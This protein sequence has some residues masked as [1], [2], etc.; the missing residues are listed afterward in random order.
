VSLQVKYTVTSHQGLVRGSNEDII[1]A[2]VTTKMDTAGA[3]LRIQ[4]LLICDGMGGMKAGET[5][6][7]LASIS[8]IDYIKSMPFWPSLES[9]IHQQLSD[10]INAAHQNIT[11]LS[12]Y[13]FATNGMGTTIVL[14][15][16]VKDHA[17]L[18]WCGDSRA[19]LHTTRIIAQGIN[20]GG[21]QLL[22]RDHSV[23]WEMVANGVLTVDQA[24]NHPKSN[25]LTQSLGGLHPPNPD[26]VSLPI[27][28]GDRFLLCSDGV[29][30]HLDSSEIKSCLNIHS[31]LELAAQA[32]SSFILERGAKDNFSIGILDVV[33]VQFAEPVL[34]VAPLASH[35]NLSR[36]SNLWHKWWITLPV[37]LAL[38]GIVYG[39]LSM[40]FIQEKQPENSLPTV[41]PVIVSN[42]NLER[43]HRKLSDATHKLEQESAKLQNITDH[44]VINI[45]K[46]TSAVFENNL[47]QNKIPAASVAPQ[48]PVKKV[49]KPSIKQ[50]DKS[51][52][53]KPLH[54]EKARLYDLI[55]NDVLMYINEYKVS[56]PN[57]DIYQ[58][59]Y[60]IRIEQL[61]FE[62]QQ[63][64]QL[65]DFTNL[66]VTNW[67]LEYLKNKFDMIQSKYKPE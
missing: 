42:Q 20:L 19:Y 40:F 61:L 39:I 50:I 51:G 66:T 13:D 53:K 49:E 62:I 47:T 54:K 14:L 9:D 29:Y 16:I 60:L 33:K 15:L 67:Q 35:D 4:G 25:A 63:K 6:S 8:V 18:I 3:A 48:K 32:M 55:Y 30:L 21:I 11:M 12:K 58:Q 64:K 45:S 57:T 17:Y 56:H 27:E 52:T 31:N 7:K 46:D 23:S 36:N 34:K 26:F 59:A 10:A 41:P 43:N 37:F 44:L 24:R 28:D 2:F 65:N 38:I 1:E 22:T 5:A